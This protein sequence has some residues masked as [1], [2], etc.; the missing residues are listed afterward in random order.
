YFDS[1]ESL[2]ATII[3]EGWGEFAAYLENGMAEEVRRSVAQNPSTDSNLVRLAYLVKAALPELFRD[4]DL[5][6][7][8]L[9][10]AGRTSRLE[11]KLDY[12]ATFVSSI[13]LDYQRAQ[14]KG[15]LQNVSVLKTGLAV[16]LLGSL[17]LMRLIF[18]ASIDIAA[19]DVIAF[20]VSTVE[21][22]LGCALPE[23]C[24]SPVPDDSNP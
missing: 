13:V 4:L 2:L 1:K 21:A 8:L 19:E 22:A 14:G 9:A 10:Q 18:H 3:E 16:M 6:A 11:E 24:A 20:L 12:L 7:I 23:L 15:E 5:I 17:E